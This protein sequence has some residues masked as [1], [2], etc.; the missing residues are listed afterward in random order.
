MKG[1][2]KCVETAMRPVPER[3]HM[4]NTCPTNAGPPPPF[5][6]APSRAMRTDFAA[7][8]AGSAV[9]ESTAV[10]EESGGAKKRGREKEEGGWGSAREGG[11]GG[12]KREAKLEAVD[13]RKVEMW[14]WRRRRWGSDGRA[15]QW[16]ST[17]EGLGV[18]GE[19]VT[20]GELGVPELFKGWR[21]HAN[22]FFFF[23]YLIYLFH[24]FLVFWTGNNLFI[25]F[26]K[27]YSHL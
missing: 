16:A 22:T 17:D 23:Y 2:S 25:S 18:W 27:E 11:F 14:L 21:P 24:L 1:M 20:E 15:I 10:E 7:G 5:P 13:W 6:L 4:L 12:L 19:R 26:N 9:A 8:R 3:S